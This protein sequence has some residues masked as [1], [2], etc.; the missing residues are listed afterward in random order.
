MQERP[1]PTFGPVLVAIRKHY[2]VEQQELAKKLVR[3]TRTLQ[4]WEHPTATVSL[5]Q[6]EWYE[7]GCQAIVAEKKAALLAVAS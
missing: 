3:T 2:G 1:A 5:L 6:V 4:R 7:A